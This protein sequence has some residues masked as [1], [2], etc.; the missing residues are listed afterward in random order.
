[1]GDLHGLEPAALFLDV[2][3]KDGFDLA[4]ALAE[5]RS[6]SEVEVRL[7]MAGR[8]EP[9][10]YSVS[11]TWVSELDSTVASYFDNSGEP[12]CC[13]L[14]VASEVTALRQQMERAKL[15]HLRASLAE[16]ERVQGMR[17]A[18]SGAIFQLQTPVNII[19]AAVG[20]LDRGAD[21]NKLREV[22]DQV[23]LS[24]QQAMDTLRG[25][26]PEETRES[27]AS[28]NLNTLLQDV[29]SLQTDAFLA[30]GVVIDWQPQTVLPSIT[31]RPNQLRSMLMRLV[32]NALL[33][34]AETDCPQRL[35]RIITVSHDDCVD[36][37]VQDNGPGIP[38]NLRLKVFEPF[39]SNWKQSR[40]RA[41]MGLPLAQETVNEHGGVIAINPDCSEGCQVRLTFPVGSAANSCDE[42]AY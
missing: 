42:G 35:L 18:L 19:Q 23:L 27:Q 24:G 32:E 7:D 26:L 20:M 10:W 38:D 25:A 33:A 17:E 30:G 29:L 14:L 41:G 39:Y 22:L 3:E 6:F 37:L 21:S 2:L 16:Q 9:R 11:G 31:G 40:G 5:C 36:V 1:M 34:V 28:V 13:L 8:T 15:Q 12:R 4:T